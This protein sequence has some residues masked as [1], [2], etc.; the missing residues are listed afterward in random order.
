ML[1]SVKLTIVYPETCTPYTVKLLPF[2]NHI[3]SGSSRCVFLRSGLAQQV[4]S[5]VS[6]QERSKGAFVVGSGVKMAGFRV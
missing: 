2:M 3:V 5:M 4:K 1:I 6:R